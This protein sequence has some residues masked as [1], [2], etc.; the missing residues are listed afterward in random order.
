MSGPPPD[1]WRRQGQE[2]YL[3]GATLFWQEYQPPSAT[4]D[5]DHCAFCW[6]TFS[7]S[8]GDLHY[9]YAANNYHWICEPC[10]R[11]FREEFRFHI[12]STPDA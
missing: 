11:D 8:E 2:K 1:D 5:H 6:E 3:L 10:F 9:G 4:W 12:G 7:L